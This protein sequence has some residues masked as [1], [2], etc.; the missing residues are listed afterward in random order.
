MPDPQIVTIESVCRPPPSAAAGRQI[1]IVK[2][3][4]AVYELGRR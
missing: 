2:S 3:R 1:G 4:F